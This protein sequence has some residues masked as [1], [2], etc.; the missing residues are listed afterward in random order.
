MVNRV[1]PDVCDMH[2]ENKVHPRLATYLVA[3]SWVVEAMKIEGWVSL[4]IF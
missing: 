3:V 4:P 1:S 2:L